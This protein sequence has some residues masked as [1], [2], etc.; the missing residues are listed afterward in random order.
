[1]RKSI[2]L[3]IAI[4][5]THCLIGQDISGKWNGILKVQSL[6]LRVVFNVEKT[7]DTYKSTMDSPDQGAMGIPVDKT[8][9]ENDQVRFEITPAQI[10]YT[11]KIINKNSIVGTFQQGGQSIPLE[12][13]KETSVTSEQ[14]ISQ[15]PVPPYPYRTEEV[16]FTN[17]KAK[18]ELAGTLTLPPN[19]GV[20]PAVIL[21]SGS[22]PQNRDEE[23]MGHK[24]FLVLADHLTKNGFAVL[25]YDDRG[26]AA[27]G[28]DFKTA[29]SFDFATDAQ[30]ALEYLASRK[31]INRKKIGMMGHSEGG[32]IAPMVA[33]KSKK[34]AFIVLLAGTGIRGD[35]LLLMQQEAIGAVSGDSEEAL[36]DA[37]KLNQSI[38]E[39]VLLNENNT[40]LKQKINDL[41]ANE[42]NKLS[43]DEFPPGIT[44]DQ[45][46]QQ[47]TDQLTSPWMYEFIRYDPS[48]ILKKVKCPVLA[49]NGSKDLQVP[50]KVNLEAIE[51]ALQLGGNKN[52]TIKELPGLNHLFQECTTGSPNEYA[53]IRQTFSPIALSEITDWLK[54]IN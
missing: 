28:G 21:I 31:E 26:T 7:D 23:L 46:I 20:Y 14:Q 42:V 4:L 11:G 48:I 25:R 51:K 39:M 44:A 18:I 10:I 53:V 19:E 52:V 17:K 8:T 6:E 12:L 38:F 36:A 43:P 24:P 3:F 33:G 47:T 2:F 1:M 54:K 15:V 30:A 34:A 27:S 37:K 40:A 5:I 13:N 22:G 35:Q 16:R 32:I 29:T 45:I 49:L 41:I 50:A 9:V